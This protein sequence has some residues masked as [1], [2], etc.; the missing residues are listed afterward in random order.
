MRAL[1]AL[2]LVS[3][4]TGTEPPSVPARTP[5]PVAS[6]SP[7]DAATNPPVEGPLLPLDGSPRPLTRAEAKRVVQQVLKSPDAVEL[8]RIPWGKHDEPPRDPHGFVGYAIETHS[9]AREPQ[10]AG[11]LLSSFLGYRGDDD[12]KLASCFAPH[13]GLVARTSR[14][15]VEVVVCFECARLELHVD[16]YDGMLEWGMRDW[17]RNPEAIDGYRDAFEALFADNGVAPAKDARTH[18]H[19]D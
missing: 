16:G 6:A 18:R 9:P 15:R 7:P 1:F 10:K 11:R 3:C 4:S 19:A 12:A 8:I 2:A 17:E 14:D 13:H 5:P